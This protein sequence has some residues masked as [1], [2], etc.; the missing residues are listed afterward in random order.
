MNRTNLRIAAF[1]VAFFVVGIPYWRIAY[2]DAQLPDVLL[3]VP[4][5]AVVIAAFV[6]RRFAGAGFMNA[7]SLAGASVPCAVMA[8]VLVETS[9]DATTHNLWPIEVVLAIGVGLIASGTG[10]LLGSWPRPST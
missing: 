7:T 1:F 2:Q 5:L 6:V 3:H 4:L 9:S 8:R 10:A